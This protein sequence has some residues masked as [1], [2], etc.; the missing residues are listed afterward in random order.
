M[1]DTSG[2]SGDDNHNGDV[3]GH[4][5]AACDGT[6]ILVEVRE[7]GRARPPRRVRMVVL[8]LDQ[9][10]AE[11]TDCLNLAERQPKRERCR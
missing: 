7:G 2:D 1:R 8:H 10:W 5:L 11:L 9:L 4:G 3:A 6:A